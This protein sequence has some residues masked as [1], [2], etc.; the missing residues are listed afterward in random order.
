MPSQVYEGGAIGSAEF[1]KTV[2]PAADVAARKA[3]LRERWATRQSGE[4]DRFRETLIK[5]YGPEKAA[6]VKF[7]EA[8][9]ICEY[10]R[11]PN[12]DEIKSLFPFFP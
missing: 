7:A 9:E 12:S 5:W 4:A 8:F 1:V 2:P 3:W 11:Q 10:G 6:A